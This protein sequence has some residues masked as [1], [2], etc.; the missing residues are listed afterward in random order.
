MLELV[1]SR[2]VLART[3]LKDFAEINL[4]SLKGLS[5]RFVDRHG[6]RQDQRQLKYV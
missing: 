2:D 6:P 4:D 3:L 1:G 5:L